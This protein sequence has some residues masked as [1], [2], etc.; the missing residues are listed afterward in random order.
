MIHI[1]LPT[2]LVGKLGTLAVHLGLK[3][4]LDLR[5]QL[6]FDLFVVHLTSPINRRAYSDLRFP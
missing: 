2:Q 3:L 5:V 1:G 6:G 4:D